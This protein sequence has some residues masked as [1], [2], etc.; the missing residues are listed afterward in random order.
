MTYFAAAY[1][2]IWLIVFI[3]VFG[4]YRRQSKIDEELATLEEIVD[5]QARH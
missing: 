2:A 4:M 5:E 1:L 3:F